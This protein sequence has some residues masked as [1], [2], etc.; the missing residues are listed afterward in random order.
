ML[1]TPE[2]RLLVYQPVCDKQCELGF[3]NKGEG[4]IREKVLN[5]SC[6]S[7]K[8][9][10]EDSMLVALIRSEADIWL[11]KNLL[12]RLKGHFQGQASDTWN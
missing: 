7:S 5:G 8:G 4:I 11:D 9:P 10:A 6:W 1:L 12:G 2:T 3:G